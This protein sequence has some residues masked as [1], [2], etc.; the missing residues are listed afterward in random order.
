MQ[1]MM[2]SDGVVSKFWLLDSFHYNDYE[3]LV[4][5]NQELAKMNGMETSRKL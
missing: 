3:A 4:Q 5:E 2:M 1:D